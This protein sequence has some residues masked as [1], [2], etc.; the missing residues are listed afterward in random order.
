MLKDADHKGEAIA[1]PVKKRVDRQGSVLGNQDIGS[2]SYCRHALTGEDQFFRKARH[3]LVQLLSSCLK[4]QERVF[5]KSRYRF[6]QLMSSC[7]DRQD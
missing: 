6:V 4:G 2:F 5:R 3:G 1:Q 7:V